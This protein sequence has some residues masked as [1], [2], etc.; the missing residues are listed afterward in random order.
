MLPSMSNP[1]VDFEEG[2]LTCVHVILRFLRLGVSKNT[3]LGCPCAEMSRDE[4]HVK[5]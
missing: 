4:L 2:S 5:R 3:V 1:A